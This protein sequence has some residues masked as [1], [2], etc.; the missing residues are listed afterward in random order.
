MHEKSS[1]H[2][3]A[4]ITSKLRLYEVYIINITVL[5]KAV[6]KMIYNNNKNKINDNCNDNNINEHPVNYSSP[7]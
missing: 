4:Y 5:I 6:I 1:C 2:Q 3:A 7:H